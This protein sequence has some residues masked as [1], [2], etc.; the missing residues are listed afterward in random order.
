MS[1]GNSLEVR[2]PILDHKVVEYVARLPMH[3]KLRGRTTKYLLK[4]AFGNLLPPEI[5][6]RPKMGFA[7]PLRHWFAR[8]LRDY[9]CDA[10]FDSRARRRGY[11]NESFVDELVQEHVSGRRDNSYML[12]RLLALEI[13]HRNAG[14]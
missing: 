12:W 6:T 10:L 9:L 13:W 11:F 7:L 2:V 4:K 8:E 1:M 14:L 3:Y 5:L